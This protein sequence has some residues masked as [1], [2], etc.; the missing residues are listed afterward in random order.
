R[1]GFDAASSRLD[2]LTRAGAHLHAPHRNR[3]SQLPVGEQLRRTLVGANEPRF[4]KSLRCDLRPLGETGEV[5]QT[6]HLGLYTED[7]RETALGKTARQRHL[8]ALE[9][10]LAAARS[11]VTRARLASLVSSAGRLALARARP[12]S[13]T[14]AIAVGARSRTQ[15]VQADLLCCGHLYHS[16]TGVTFTRCRTCLICPRSDGES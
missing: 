4:R 13:H 6:Y 12:A 1:L 5:V 2:L 15:V 10:R 9:V 7:V 16:S 8:A 3:T 11:V 14:L